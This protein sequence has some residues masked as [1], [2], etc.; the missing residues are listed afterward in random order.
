MLFLDTHQLKRRFTLPIVK[1]VWGLTRWTIFSGFFLKLHRLSLPL[2]GPPWSVFLKQKQNPTTKK[3]F[4][5]LKKMS[6]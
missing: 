5:F 4:F 6:C 2:E 3:L 1:T